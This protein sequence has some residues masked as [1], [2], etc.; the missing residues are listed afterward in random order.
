[1]RARAVWDRKQKVETPDISGF[2]IF[3]EKLKSYTAIGVTEI[4]SQ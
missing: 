1:M 3:A 2:L 4:A